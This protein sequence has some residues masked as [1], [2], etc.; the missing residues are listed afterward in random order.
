M[1]IY[2]HLFS[3]L[4]DVIISPKELNDDF[5]NV[6]DWAFQLKINFIIDPSKPAKEVILVVNKRKRHICIFSKI[7]R[8][9][10]RFQ[11]RIL[12]SSQ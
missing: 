11:S 12:K 1:T 7:P 10:I 5:R 8:C 9:C 3:L 2:Q 6:N 4:H